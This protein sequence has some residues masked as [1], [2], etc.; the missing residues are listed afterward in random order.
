MAI[1]N[2]SKEL[3]RAEIEK[4]KVQKTGLNTEIDSLQS[5]INDLKL[6]REAINTK[7]QK[8]KDDAEA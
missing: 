3:I 5:R 2:E 1:S 4:L 8:F 7:L 6:Q